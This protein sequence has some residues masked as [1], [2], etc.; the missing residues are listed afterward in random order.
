MATPNRRRTA[1]PSA[2]PPG[3]TLTL[4]V[5]RG[6][7]SFEAAGVAWDDGALV[8]RGLLDM[9][10]LVLRADPGAAPRVDTVH[11]GHAVPVTDDDGGGRRRLG[12][13]R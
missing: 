2:D 11:A 4:T 13:V 8:A 9:L 6:D 3:P 12:F 10:D 5:G 1:T 7:V